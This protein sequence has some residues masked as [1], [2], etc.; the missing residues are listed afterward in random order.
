MD[1][2]KFNATACRILTELGLQPLLKADHPISNQVESQPQ[3][4]GP[5]TIVV[6]VTQFDGKKP[7]V[8]IDID[9]SLPEG[10]ILANAF[11]DYCNSKES[12]PK[13][14]SGKYCAGPRY[15]DYL[16]QLRGCETFAYAPF[17][18]NFFYVRSEDYDLEH[19]EEAA[20]NASALAQRF[21]RHIPEYAQQR[22][23]TVEDEDVKTKAR[24]IIENADLEE[25]DCDEENRAHHLRD[26]KSFFKGWFYPFNN[27]GRGT[28]D[29]VWPSSLEYAASG[30]GYRGSFEYAVAS[31]LLEN[32]DFIAKA[33]KACRIRE[34]TKIYCY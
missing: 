23:W 13:D 27:H 5:V 14:L 29:T 2:E 3:A 24:E 9:F 26:A 33:R 32:D 20:T 12:I 28:F 31:I 8:R 18:R 25:T 16:S 19:L 7:S 34:E 4:I 15:K 10:G 30:M 22:V 6:T 1:T 21:V 11:M 17:N